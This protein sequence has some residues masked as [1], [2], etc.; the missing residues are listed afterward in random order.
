VQQEAP[1]RPD[2]QALDQGEGQ[3]LA[4]SQEAEWGALGGSGGAE[5][6]GEAEGGL[7]PKGGPQN[8]G[9]GGFPLPLQ[10]MSRRP[11][12]AVQRQAAQARVLGPLTVVPPVGGGS[13]GRG[14]GRR[15]ERGP[16]NAV[17]GSGSVSLWD[18]DAEEGEEGG[19]VLNRRSA[20]SGRGE[21]GEG[22][23]RGKGSLY[24]SAH[25]LPHQ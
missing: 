1:S 10:A 16:W 20:G 6:S 3:P 15:G 9:P 2:P 23:G 7:A 17:Q 22:G 8:G 14:A 13:P 11:Q 5:R 19:R 18:F 24:A 25:T 21:L 4:L 12:G